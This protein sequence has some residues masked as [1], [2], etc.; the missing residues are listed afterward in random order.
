MFP[1][2]KAD[3][4]WLMI[5]TILVIMMTLP[6]VALFYGGL[7]RAKNT[8]SVLVQVFAIFCLISLLW[9]AF[10]YSIAFT[11]GNP[12]F[13]GLD[14][15]FLQG[16]SVDS[17][18]ETFTKG[19]YIPEFAFMLFQLSFA[20][21]TTAL[22]VGGLAERIKF[23]ALLIFSALWFSLSYL[24]IA[25]MVWFWGG[26]SDY[27]GASGFL[28]GKGVLDFAGGTVV[29]INAAIAALV[30]ALMLGKRKGYGS[31]EINP[32]SL[33]STMIGA[34]LLWVGWF[35]FNAGSNLEATGTAVLAMVNTLVAT[36]A[37]ALAWMTTEWSIKGKPSLFGITSGAIA[38]LVVITPAAGF[39]GPMGAI[40]LGIVAGIAGFGGVTILKQK[41]GYDDALDVFGIHGIAGIIG[42][43]GTGI[44][45]NPALGGTGIFDYA[46][47]TIAT[48]SFFQITTQIMGVGVAIGWS[49]LVSILLF[50]ILKYTIGLRVSDDTEEKGLDHVLH[51]EK[52]Y[53][54]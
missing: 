47:G 17:A 46:T 39:S 14:K 5:S 19:V 2:E 53:D 8:I 27:S 28:F 15:I 44:I 37:A 7:V 4:V 34:S 6:G 49:A 26:P 16:I 45:V 41:L 23:S 50:G 51:G 32:H 1:I 40:I 12:F 43:I 54:M 52:A 21:I 29:H 33:V 9:V 18:V 10:G 31:E 25:H 13:G 22:I 30:G 48:Y 35:G 3:T 24:P 11:G 38:G 42:A 36:S 20:A